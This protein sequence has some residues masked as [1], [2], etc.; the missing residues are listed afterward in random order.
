[1]TSTSVII[2][3]ALYVLLRLG[4]SLF[5]TYK[6]N[7]AIEKTRA[8]MQAETEKNQLA[9][10]LTT[11]GNKINELDLKLAAGTFAVDEKSRADILHVAQRL[12]AIEQALQI[13]DSSIRQIVA[14]L[15]PPRSREEVR[16][17][18]T[19]STQAPNQQYT[20]ANGPVKLTMEEQIRAAREAAMNATQ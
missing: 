1:M 6:N 17:E 12:G 7:V 2:G 14:V 18:Q 3:I 20:V 15:T 4:E 5:N 13:Q 11:M 8:K 16:S 9:A 10:V 19:F